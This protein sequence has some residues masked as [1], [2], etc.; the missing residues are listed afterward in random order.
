[1]IALKEVLVAGHPI[2]ELEPSLF[3]AFDPD[4]ELNHFGTHR[5]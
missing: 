4:D 5:F 1:V 3:S 2:R